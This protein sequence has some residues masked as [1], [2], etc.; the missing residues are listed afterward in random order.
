MKII[1]AI[2]IAA[3]KKKGTERRLLPSCGLLQLKNEPVGVCA[4][5]ETTPSKS[6]NAAAIGP[7]KAFNPNASATSLRPICAA[8]EFSNPGTLVTAIKLFI[9]HSSMNSLFQQFPL[10]RLIVSTS[11][12]PF[13]G[14]ASLQLPCHEVGPDV[15]ERRRHVS[16]TGPLDSNPASVDHHHNGPASS[17]SWA[18]PPRKGAR[19]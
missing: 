9:F 2:I 7:F 1:P 19:I 13:D 8:R 10:A 11:R 17:R 14:R 18:I 16:Q 6:S 5:A 15:A 4:D 3:A 12:E